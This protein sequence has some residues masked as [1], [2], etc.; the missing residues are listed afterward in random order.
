M[1][2]ISEALAMAVQHHQAGQLQAAEQMCLQILAVAPDHADAWYLLGLAS[3]QLG[4]HQT[5]IECFRRALALAPDFAGAHNNLGNALR[6]Q[7]KLDDAVAFCRRAV[8]LQPDFA[9]AHHNLGNAF[10]DQGKIDQAVA[11]YRRALELKPAFTGPCYEL[12]NVL[13]SQ[14][15][16]DEA[17]T[18]YRKVVQLEWGAVPS[19][20]EDPNKSVADRQPAIPT[21]PRSVKP[22]DRLGM[23]FY[24]LAT[25]FES[26]LS[27]DD[28]LAMRQLLLDPNLCDDD[29]AAVQFG[30][31]QVL[32]ARG[33][34]SAA[35]EHVGKANAARRAALKKRKQAYSPV[36]HRSFV[37]NMLATFTPQY[38]ARV[39]G[40]GL[41][42]ERPV[43]IV[44]LP[45]SG[46]TLVEQI[47]ASHSQVFGAGEIRYCYE[48]FQSLPKTMNRSDTP[49]RCLRDL[50]RGAS[51]CL[52]QQHLD[53]L[54]VLDQR[55]L[56]I[57]DKMPD[58]Y[59]YL[60]LIR[61]LFPQSQLIHCRR[62]LRDVALSCWM[63]NFTSVPWAYDPDH[64]VVCFEEYSRL[65]DHWR[66]V[67]PSPPL[68][69]DY[70]ELVEDTEGV[71][72]R[73]VKWCGLEW[74]P[75]CL[76]FHQTQRPVRTA[77]AV[78]VRR[79]IYRTSVRRWKDYETSLSGLFSQV[80][81]LDE[82][83]FGRR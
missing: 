30:L 66:K 17:V 64:I 48:T 38:F 4:K 6:E 24:Q 80:R 50:D 11:C 16:L 36:K 19:G 14:G 46:T 23:A 45:R 43:F 67:L 54:R 56:R 53:R 70:E 60:G 27:E 59:H 39:G 58:N 7:G 9:M 8:E 12:G 5:G 74:E 47:L 1:A 62:D 78:Q 79:P 10:K 34:Y 72:R 13:K 44:G 82:I 65:M 49:F 57:V 73:L 37:S 18:C 21:R 26:R 3:V 55:A 51:R 40:F 52:A 35:A 75:A 83:W 29:R 2:T 41:E 32:H 68:D 28:L 77:S 71:A 15:K 33:E 31:A 20:P 69:V 42:T 63:T 22:Y 61:T 76:H 81:R 25:I